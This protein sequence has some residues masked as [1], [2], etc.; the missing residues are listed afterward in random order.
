IFLQ[1]PLRR[2]YLFHSLRIRIVFIHLKF[3]SSVYLMFLFGLCIFNDKLAFPI[4]LCPNPTW[5]YS[6][7][8]DISHGRVCSSLCETAVIIVISATICMRAK[9]NFYVWI[10]SEEHTSELQSREKLV[11]RLLLENRNR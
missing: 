2:G 5:V 3:C 1:N 8:N 7:C 10:R 11:C 4:A 6:F 9:F